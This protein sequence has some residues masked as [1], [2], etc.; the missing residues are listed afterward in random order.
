MLVLP[1]LLLLPFTLWLLPHGLS[2][3]FL[4]CFQNFFS[5][6]S[7]I[8]SKLNILSV[9]GMD[10]PNSFNLLKKVP[11]LMLLVDW[12]CGAQWL[13]LFLAVSALL[14]PISEV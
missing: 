6:Y 10:N 12:K 3:T 9:L 14:S 7:K 5:P 8:L 2:I 13:M 11:A 4:F 1:E